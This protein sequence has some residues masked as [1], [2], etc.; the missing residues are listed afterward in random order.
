MKTKQMRTLILTVVFLLFF[1][2][3]WADEIVTLKNGKKAMIKDDGTWSYI[4]I[5]PNVTNAQYSEIDLV[6]LKLDID[7]LTGKKI[8]TQG[9]AQFFADM[10]MLKQE[11]MD[12]NP[13]LIDY[14]KTSR[15]ERKFILTKCSTGCSITV[16]GQVGE[17]DFQKGIIADRIEW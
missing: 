6:D 9:L 13:L 3:S 12:M 7:A 2:F 16:F 17:V 11:M 15:D 4:N 5:S 10:L 8:K 14:K 1:S